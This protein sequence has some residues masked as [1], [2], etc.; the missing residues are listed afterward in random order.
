MLLL[1]PW[2]QVTCD[3]LFHVLPAAVRC[4]VAAEMARICLAAL[5]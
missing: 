2:A 5:W 3:Y 4:K 1:A